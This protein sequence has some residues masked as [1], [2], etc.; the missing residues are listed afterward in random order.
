MKKISIIGGSGFIG[1]NL[2]LL[3]K[4]EGFDVSIIDNLEIN[5]L[6]SIKKNENNLPFPKLSTL[7]LNQRIN[8]LKEKKISLIKIDAKNH[9]KINETLGE[10]KPNIIIHLAAVSHA[11]RSNVDPHK[12]I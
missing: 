3:L 8:F 11:N 4:E 2:A 1:H 6:G 12:N 7:I 9:K 5:N 10:V